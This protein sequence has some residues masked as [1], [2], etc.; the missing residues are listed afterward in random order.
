MPPLTESAVAFSPETHNLMP[1]QFSYTN[2]TTGTVHPSS[3]W[4]AKTINLD[5]VSRTGSYT[6]NGYDT[7]DAFTAG[8]QPFLTASFPVTFS[9]APTDTNAQNVAKI[10]TDALTQ[11]FFSQNNAQVVA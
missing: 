9:P 7:K 3:Y 2:K 6:I 5:L 4:V 11:P 1:L 8:K 10:Y